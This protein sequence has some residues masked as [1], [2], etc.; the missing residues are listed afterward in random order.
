MSKI[1]QE[2]LS[3]CSF[4]YFIKPNK[5]TLDPIYMFLSL[6]SLCKNGLFLWI[7][8][9]FSILLPYSD[10]LATSN[11]EG[12]LAF[13]HYLPTILD[14]KNR[15]IKFGVLTSKAGALN[16]IPLNNGSDC[17]LIVAAIVRAP[18][19]DSPNIK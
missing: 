2:I 13:G 4:M 12:T 11:I 1:G 15:I 6:S 14:N 17:N 10:L 3:K 8:N 19:N 5:T 7:S 16:I 18:P 9:T